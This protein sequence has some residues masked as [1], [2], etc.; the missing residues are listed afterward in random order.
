MLG[1]DGAPFLPWEPAA[2]QCDFCGRLVMFRRVTKSQSEAL[3]V[4]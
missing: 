3:P 2:E 1:V 4:L